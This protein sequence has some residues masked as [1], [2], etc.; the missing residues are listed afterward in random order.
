MNS[1]FELKKRELS[2]LKVN[3]QIIQDKVLVIEENGKKVLI[4]CEDCYKINPTASATG[5]GV[6][7]GA[8]VNYYERFK[9]Q[10][11]IPT[12]VAINCWLCPTCGRPFLELLPS[13]KLMDVEN[14]SL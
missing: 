3:F 4:G 11:S 7:V 5:Y 13:F 12:E 9:E 6:E 8:L 14:V 1:L 10:S 2:A